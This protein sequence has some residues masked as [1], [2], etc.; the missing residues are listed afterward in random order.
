MV[1]SAKAVANAL[2]D[3]AAKKGKFLTNLEL[4]KLVYFAHGWCLALT[5]NPLFSDTMQAWKYGPVSLDLYQSLRQYGSGVVTETIPIHPGTEVAP[6]SDD[7]E[8]LELIMDKYGRFSPLQL[9]ALSHSPG[10][11]WEQCGSGNDPYREIP[12]DLIRDYFRAQ[13]NKPEA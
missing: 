13:C 4:Q 5:G 8:F 10:S 3:I 12:N 6:N 9:M 1:Y 11:P 7:Y 2:L